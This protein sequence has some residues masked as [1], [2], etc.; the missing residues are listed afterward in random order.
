LANRISERFFDKGHDFD[1]YHK[2]RQILSRVVK[3]TEFEVEKEIFRGKVYD[4]KKVGSILYKGSYKGRDAVLKIQGL[5]VDIDEIEIIRKFEAQ[6]KSKI[7]HAPKI[8]VHKRWD[9][10][11]GYGFTISEYSTAV[12]IF[13]RPFASA[14]QTKEFGRFYQEYRTKAVTKDFLERPK[15]DTLAGSLAK[16]DYW[17]K[18]CENKGILKLEDYA[19][20]LM[21]YYPLA[22]KHLPTIPITMSHNHITPED[23]LRNKD[24]SFVLMS[25]LFWGHSY[26][27]NELAMNVWHCWMAI[28]DT[29]YTYEQLLKYVKGWIAAYKRI[30]IVKADKDFD[31]KFAM[32]MLNRSI[33]TILA[34]LGGAN[35][36]FWGKMEN[37]KYLFHL[38]HLEQK[39]FDHF[40]EQLGEKR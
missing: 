13:K 34:D 31:R 35:G 5:Q 39:L 18:L 11:A 14:A 32:Q 30:P 4:D 12:P 19:P 27:Y 3:K 9:K 24:G 25:N 23:V 1:L 36:Y 40:A 2:E 26:Q 20:Y 16:V 33:G 29:S 15:G 21:R 7:I 37:R 22:A 10:K 28:R 6:N 38:L 17:R 8:F